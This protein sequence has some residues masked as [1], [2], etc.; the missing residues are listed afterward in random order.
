VALVVAFM[1]RFVQDDAFISFT[2]ARSL[3]QGQGLTWFGTRVEGYTNFF[4]VLWSALGM[5]LGIE[6]VAWAH[7]GGLAAFAATLV[8]TWR[9]GRAVLG[10]DAP[11]LLA[12]GLLAGNASVLA[13]ATGGLETMPQTALLTWAMRSLVQLRTGPA[14]GAAALRTC[15]LL[16]WLVAGAILMRIDSALPAAIL[17][18]FAATHLRA[19][20][21]PGAVWWALVAPLAGIAGGW[22]VWK[23]LYYGSLLPN[24]FYAKVGWRLVG[25]RNGVVYLGR[26]LHWYGLW[27][28]VL[29][30]AAALWLRARRG[31]LQ[32]VW[33]RRA[34]PLAAVLLAWWLYVVLIGGDFMEFRMLVPMAPVFAVLLAGAVYDGLGAGL[35]RPRLVA[36]VV[37]AALV[38]ASA[39]HARRFT[40]V[41]PDRTLDS[42]SA[43]ANFYSVVEDGDWARLG[44]TLGE[45]LAGTG[46]VLAVHAAGAIPYYSGLRTVDMYGLNDAEV[47]RHGNPARYA[48]P[49]HQRQIAVAEMRRRGVHFVIAHPTFVR[50]GV[51]AHPGAAAF[52][53]QWVRDAVSFDR[54]RIGFTTLVAMPVTADKALLLWY[55]TPTPQLDARLRERGW[56]TTRL[57]VR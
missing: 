49:G 35:G 25:V 22:G 11:A 51:L 34:A 28:V 13:F 47:A 2:Y 29:L 56:E 50:R 39:L 27:P 1:V 52:N 9:L 7:A 40:G 5:R 32:D 45:Q 14:V 37:A 48:R 24:T 8:G 10:R 43:L 4:W 30:A 21:A 26:F 6:P 15:G 55:L 12:L 19:Q 20:R 54:E 17:V 16:S 46:A 18:G 42:V 3:V 31:A 33:P 44:R 23:L 41:T 57:Y 36:A 38:V 53:E